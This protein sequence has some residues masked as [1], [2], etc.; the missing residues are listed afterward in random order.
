MK[1]GDGPFAGTPL[2]D[3]RTVLLVHAHPDD[4]TISTG[5][6]LAALADSGRRTVLV[7]ATRGELGEAVPGPH[8]R[9]AG[10][11]AFAAHREGELHR[12]LAELGPV[13]HVFLGSPP[14]RA[15]GLAP[16]RYTDSGMRWIRPGL[17]GPGEQAG[18]EA[19]TSAPAAEVVADLRALCERV[20][21]DAIVGD[22]EEGGYG[23]PDHVRCHLAARAVAEE[24]DVP[25]YG[26]V[27]P[28]GIDAEQDPE[29]AERAARE[30]LEA[31]PGEAF[32]LALEP[33]LPR[34]LAALRRHES[35]LTVEDGHMVH[36]GGQRQLVRPSIGLLRWP[37]AGDATAG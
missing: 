26:I 22:D 21:P 35:Q 19:L 3:C 34:Q 15:A 37:A 5:A 29:R 23:H 25:G 18:P 1:A 4:E 28:G 24:L 36:S 9:L 33:W 8:G 17:A 14:A 16:R 11:G 27:L 10:T 32:R 7:T 13:E 6:L 2:A 31:W 30:R 12:A 20:R